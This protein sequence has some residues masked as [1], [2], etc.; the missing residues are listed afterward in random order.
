MSFWFPYLSSHNVTRDTRAAIAD[1]LRHKYPLRS[2]LRRG[3]GAKDT[4]RSARDFGQW[5]IRRWRH[6][7]PLLK[8]PIAL[9]STEWLVEEFSVIPWYSFGIPEPLLAAYVLAAHLTHLATSLHRRSL[10][11][12]FE[13]IR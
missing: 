12:A 7:R 10:W 3:Q 6:D 8:D 2:E 13:S 4:L 11:T 9:L 1:L 5:S